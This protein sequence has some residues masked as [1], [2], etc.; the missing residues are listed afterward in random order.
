MFQIS[1]QSIKAHVSYSNFKKCCE[2][3]KEKKNTKKIQ[4]TLKAHILETAWWI[5]LKF[6]IGDTP[7]QG[8]SHIKFHVFLFGEY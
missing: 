1:R 4:Q 8:N 3:K 5:Q 7:P 6:G 2:K